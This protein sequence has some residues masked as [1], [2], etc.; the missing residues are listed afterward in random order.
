MIYVDIRFE[1]INHLKLYIKARI[2]KATKI[3]DFPKDLQVKEMY[4]KIRLG[5]H[6]KFH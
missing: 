3:F 4:H 1:I 6:E 5:E 2:I